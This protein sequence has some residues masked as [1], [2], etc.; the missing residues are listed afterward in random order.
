MTSIQRPGGP[1]GPG[2]LDAATDVADATPASATSATGAAQPLA[3]L[4]AAI[5]SGQLSA[6]DALT[7]LIEQ[8]VAGLPPEEADA[9]RADLAEMFASDPYLSGLAGGLGAPLDPGEGA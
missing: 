7:Q 5:D 4:A 3:D 8:S 9:L 1:T 6:Q 2:G